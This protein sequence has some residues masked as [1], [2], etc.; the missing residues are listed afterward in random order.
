MQV[1]VLRVGKWIRLQH[2]TCSEPVCNCVPT[3]S[4][5]TFQ[6]CYVANSSGNRSDDER[7]GAGFPWELSEDSN[8]E[9]CGCAS[10]NMGMKFIQQKAM[11]RIVYLK[12][13][14]WDVEIRG[15]QVADKNI[16]TSGFWHDGWHD[17]TYLL[18]CHQEAGTASPYKYIWVPLI[19]QKF[20]IHC[21][22]WVF[23]A[24]L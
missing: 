15:K 11:Q 1:S 21:R 7:F 23:V 10:L 20:S 8:W 4:S 3:V 12:R 22:H 9:C 6:K 17:C 2:T 13:I 24:I 18:F 14:Y 19:A 16:K 5:S